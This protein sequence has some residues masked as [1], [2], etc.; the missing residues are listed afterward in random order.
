[1]KVLVF[2]FYISILRYWL[3][4]Q[5][6]KKFKSLKW[7]NS[8]WEDIFRKLFSIYI[9]YIIIYS[10][11]NK[12]TLMNIDWKLNSFWD[13]KIFVNII[14]MNDL[15]ALFTEDISHIFLSFPYN[16]KFS[17]YR[18][19]NSLEKSW[20]LSNYLTNMLDSIT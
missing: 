8:L 19:T 6:E 4:M 13:I 7:W 12:K 2:I 18:V 14:I 3:C 20:S 5:V 16:F 15:L 17:L 11:L 10:I 1:L 9:I